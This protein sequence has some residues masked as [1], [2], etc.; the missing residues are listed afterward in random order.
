MAKVALEICVKY[1]NK[2]DIFNSKIW[3][4]VALD[5]VENNFN[6]YRFSQNDNSQN[7]R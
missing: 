1:A 5:I 2:N 4:N 3:N 6:L 7:I